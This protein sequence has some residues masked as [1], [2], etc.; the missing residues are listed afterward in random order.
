MDSYFEEY[1]NYGNGTE[2]RY[3]LMDGECKEFVEMPLNRDRNDSNCDVL[4]H[5]NYL[6]C[7]PNCGVG[8]SDMSTKFGCDDRRT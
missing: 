7:S 3:E 4:P 2:T 1:L 8:A 5:G 6:T